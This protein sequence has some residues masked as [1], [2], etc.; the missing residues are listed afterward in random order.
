[1]GSKNKGPYFKPH[2]NNK[3]PKSGAHT[4]NQGQA[5]ASEGSL[6]GAPTTEETRGSTTAPPA[7]VG[8]RGQSANNERSIRVCS[9]GCFQRVSK[10][11]FRYC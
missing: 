5:E 11:V 10:S 6:K 8:P 7:K 4:L 3:G 9:L 1:M 2:P